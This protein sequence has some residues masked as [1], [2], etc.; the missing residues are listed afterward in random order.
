VPQN[1]I[2][3]LSLSDPPVKTRIFTVS[4][5]RAVKVVGL[6]K[7]ILESRRCLLW[8]QALTVDALDSASGDIQLFIIGKP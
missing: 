7:V 3:H 5:P 6:L 8:G 2:K 1:Q 4:C